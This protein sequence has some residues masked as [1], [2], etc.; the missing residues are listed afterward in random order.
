MQSL[1]GDRFLRKFAGD[2][3]HRRKQLANL[4]KDQT[5]EAKAELAAEMNSQ[6]SEEDREKKAEDSHDH[7]DIMGQDEE[8]EI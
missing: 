5:P 3:K 2:L 1:L 6:L 8:D 7:P 4:L